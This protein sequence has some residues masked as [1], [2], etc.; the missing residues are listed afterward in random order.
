MKRHALAAF[1]SGRGEVAELFASLR[2]NGCTVD[3]CLLTSFGKGFAATMLVDGKKAAVSKAVKSLKDR[4][5][6]KASP[7]EQYGPALPGNLQITLYGPN[8]PETLPLLSG[9]INSEGAEITEIE[10]KSIGA[11]SVVAMQAWCPGKTS[12]IR[13]RLKDLSKKLGLKASIEKISPEDLV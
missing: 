11:M 8:R 5:V 1:G 13:A 6:I 3:S 2:E 12:V 7:V 4:F 10:S 9:I